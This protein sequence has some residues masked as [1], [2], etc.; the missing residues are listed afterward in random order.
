MFPEYFLQ[1]ANLLPEAALLLSREGTILAVNRSAGRL[2]SVPV[3]EVCG[4]RVADFLADPAPAVEAYL[5]SCA[6][7]TGPVP[8]RLTVRRPDG[9]TVSCQARGALLP[10][11]VGG[12]VTRDTPERAAPV[13]FLRLVPHSESA[14]QFALLNRHIE[15]LKREIARRTRAEAERERQSLALQHAHEELSV[16]NE[17]LQSA[18]EELVVAN[19]E[20]QSQQQELRRANELKDRFLTTLAHELRNPLGPIRAAVHVLGKVDPGSPVGQRNRHIVERQVTHMSRLVEDLLDVSRLTTGRI[21]LQEESFDLTEVVRETVEDYRATLEREGLTLTLVL[22]EEPAWMHGDTVRISQVLANLLTNA[23]KFTPLGGEVTVRLHIEADR[24]AVLS[25]RDTGVGIPPDELPYIFDAFTQGDRPRQEASA[26]LGLGLAL[27]K[28]LV[29]L[30][31]G[32]MTARSAGPG[33][34]AELIVR[35]PLERAEA[36]STHPASGAGRARSGR[37]LI[38]EDNQDAAE[39][40]RDLLELCGY[41]VATVPT[42]EEGVALAPHFQPAVVLSDL[43]LPGMSGYAVA[44]ALRRDPSL[45]SVRL[46]AVSGYGAD[47]DRRR[48]QEAGFD[49]HLVKPLDP[50]ALLAFLKSLTAH[51]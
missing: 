47:E 25:V 15:E 20:L 29:A 13:L 42:G 39:S 36:L 3:A 45:G 24:F 21:R 37:V 10:P 50:E 23:R 32:E 22:P 30:H 9:E 4:Q 28:G 26:G 27:A 38:I 8:G 5:G 6:R 17:E 33:Q 31:R 40:L 1:I 18:N 46:I 41:E 44:E 48:C 12:A 19:E 2:L 34:G 49:A 11:P 16:S 35:F 51:R 43:G 14:S 7:T